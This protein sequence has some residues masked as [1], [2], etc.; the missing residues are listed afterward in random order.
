MPFTQINNIFPER[1]SK[2]YVSTE[3]HI[4]KSPAKS[5]KQ[6]RF[7]TPQKN[8]NLPIGSIF[9]Q[10][11]LHYTVRLMAGRF[12]LNG[13]KSSLKSDEISRISI[14]NLSLETISLCVRLDPQVL[15]LSLQVNDGNETSCFLSVEDDAADQE[16]EENIVV[17]KDYSPPKPNKDEELVKADE[18]KEKDEKEKLLDIKFDHFCD[19][20]ENPS[21]YFYDFNLE[22]EIDQDQIHKTTKDDD[23]KNTEKNRFQGITFAEVELNAAMSTASVAEKMND[24]K[25]YKIPSDVP[26]AE[27]DFQSISDVLLYWSHS[28]PMLRGHVQII[29]GYYFIGCT[30][31]QR[32]SGDYILG[33]CIKVRFFMFINFCLK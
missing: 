5:I 2:F 30:E 32:N 33:I 13:T 24:Q 21:G 11:L 1:S 31:E 3:D 8:H 12:L 18:L 28:D 10:S 9:S 4:G 26:M 15:Q 6:Q 16:E 25:S 14:K 20:D 29:A 27:T 17:E 7:Q 22:S 23:G 19:E